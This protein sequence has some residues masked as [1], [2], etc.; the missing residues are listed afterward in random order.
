[1][2]KKFN[3]AHPLA[4]ALRAGFDNKGLAPLHPVVEKSPMVAVFALLLP[5]L[6]LAG[7]VSLPASVSSP[8]HFYRL[9]LPE[10]FSSVT[11]NPLVSPSKLLVKVR[12][13]DA[14]RS[15]MMILARSDY[16]LVY[17]D[18][19][20]W[21]EPLGDGMTRLLAGE[22]RPDFAEVE[23]TPVPSGY[24]CDYRVEVTIDK[25]WGTPKG[26]V[27]L[28]ARWSVDDSHDTPL[29]LGSKAFS[30]KGWDV[31][32]YK[33]F[34]KRVSNLTPQLAA[35]IRESVAGLEAKKNP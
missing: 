35:A 28:E 20:R 17:E 23:V 12:V 6:F 33:D 9:E 19:Q 21:A 22:L 31:G 27:A 5:I 26:E 7:C 16:E 3:L 13:S 4:P 14:L 30:Q 24:V 15:P 25:L 11:Q 32:D 18:T 1:M 8:T 29:I 2:N 34:A 10:A